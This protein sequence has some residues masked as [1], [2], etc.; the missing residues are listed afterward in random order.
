MYNSPPRRAP[1]RYYYWRLVL[2]GRKVLFLTVATFAKDNPMFQTSC[3]IAII[4]VAYGMQ[5]S[6]SPFVSAAEQHALVLLASAA[7]ARARA[8]AQ[9]RPAHD[10]PPAP[11]GGLSVVTAQDH[12]AA[13]AAAAAGSAAAPACGAAAPGSSAAPTVR[14]RRQS[15]VIALAVA[16]AAG[17]TMEHITD[18][19]VLESVLLMTCFGVM[20]GGAIFK[21]AVFVPGDA[22][23]WTLTVAILG[24]LLAT[25]GMFAWMTLAEVRRAFAAAAVREAAAADARVIASLGDGDGG[26]AGWTRNPIRGAATPA[27]PRPGQAAAVASAG[28]GGGGEIEC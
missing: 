18:F 8:R 4:A 15:V 7:Q 28:G 2:I 26:F 19:N 25:M 27:P 12:G 13:A 16:A 1:R 10:G 14:G 9:S 21:S 17:A 11:V 23:D 6:L 24:L 3:A 5:R 22:F 20:L